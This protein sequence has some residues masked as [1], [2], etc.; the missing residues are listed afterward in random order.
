MTALQRPDIRLIMRRLFAFILPVALAVVLAG[1]NRN[2]PEKAEA[3]YSCFARTSLESGLDYVL[4]NG[5]I[6]HAG[7]NNID[8]YI[9]REGRRI[10]MVF[11][12]AEDLSQ[13]EVNIRLFQVDTTVKIGESL[14]VPSA[15]DIPALGKDKIDVMLSPHEPY[16][17]PEYINL[18]VHY[19][20]INGYLH[21]FY[22]VQD[23]SKYSILDEYLELKLVHDDGGD[24]KFYD[25]DQWVC[26]PVAPF[27]DMFEG[28]SG[29]RIEID[30]QKY[31]V[32]YI[33]LSLID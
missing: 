5:Q 32:Q 24:E 22:L 11:S 13:H 27:K 14:I 10:W 9:P 30:T 16:V 19:T 17:S 6:F 20:G 8:R 33:T 18:K 15:E 7:K 4:E 1:C 23:A 28:K 25:V 3:Y 29:I 26:F 2:E 21:N 12:T 31:G